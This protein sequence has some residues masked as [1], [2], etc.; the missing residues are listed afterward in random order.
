MPNPNFTKFIENNFSS[1]S[2]QTYLYVIKRFQATF[3]NLFS[4]DVKELERY[5][6]EL[7]KQNKSI[8]YRQTQLAAI[9]CFYDWCHSENLINENPS[10]NFHFDEK[11]PEGINFKQILSYEELETLLTL[12]EERYK[13]MQS[14]NQSI[15]SLL[16]YQGLTS[17]ELCEMKVE[18]LDLDAGLVSI[19]GQGQNI[20]R[21]LGLRNNQIRP[22]IDYIEKD[23]K[24][25]QITNTKKLFLSM[26]GD[27]LTVD[28][29]HELITRLP[30]EGIKEISPMNIRRSVIY[31]WVNVRKLPLEHVK[32]MAGH[33]NISSTE[34]YL[35][36]DWETQREKLN[37]LFS[38]L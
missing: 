8:A 6:L 16:I 2:V 14:R 33:R 7:K 5:F 34:K 15:I 23:R 30:N 1:S 32:D 35:E 29:L 11:K 12:K 3:P 21:T 20:N 38:K 17:K 28:A 24:M 9:K 26:R 37:N 25:K 22:L 4:V 31:N 13:Y 19:M 10:Q 27:P 18:D 36:T